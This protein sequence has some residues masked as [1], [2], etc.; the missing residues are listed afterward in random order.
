[1]S[2]R[3]DITRPS[4]LDPARRRHKYFQFSPEVNAGHLLQVLVLAL[5]GLSMYGAWQAERAT[6]RL[7]VDQIKRDAAADAARTK[8]SIV[9]LKTEMRKVQD[10]LIELNLNLVRMNAQMGQKE[11]AK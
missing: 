8:E 3:D 6:N 2:E 5:G 9:E 1:M 4:D 11:H 7:E 10:N